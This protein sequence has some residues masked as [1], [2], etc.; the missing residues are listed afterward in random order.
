MLENQSLSEIEN[1]T[2]HNI[3]MVFE[4]I[5]TFRDIVSLGAH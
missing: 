4:L 3:F 5:S 1:Y 2:S